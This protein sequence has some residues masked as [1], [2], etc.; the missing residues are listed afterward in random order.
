MSRLETTPANPTHGPPRRG[1][2]EPRAVA[3]KVPSR[4]KYHIQKDCIPASHFH[5]RLTVTKITFSEYQFRTSADASDSLCAWVKE[6]LELNKPMGK[7]TL[8]EIPTRSSPDGFQLPNHQVF[9]YV[10]G[11]ITP[12]ATGLGRQHS[13]PHHQRNP[14]RVHWTAHGDPNFCNYC[15]SEGHVL[16]CWSSS[17]SM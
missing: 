3:Y 6:L 10:K 2:G 5:H 11:D 8:I 15:K 12:E 14:V 1:A 9:V 13:L 16:G 7:V 17:G 4:Y